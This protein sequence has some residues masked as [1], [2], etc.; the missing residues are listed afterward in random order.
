MDAY[1]L[2]RTEVEKIIREGMKWNEEQSEKWHARMAGIE[3]VFL[4]QESSLFVITVY[5]ESGK[6]Q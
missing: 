2:G 3:C 6:K 5:L 1:G 4:K